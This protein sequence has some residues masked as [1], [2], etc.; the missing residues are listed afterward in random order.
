MAIYTVGV[1][2]TAWVA[3]TCHSLNCRRVRIRENY[4]VLTVQPS[5]D[6]KVRIPSINSSMVAN[7][8]VGGEFELLPVNWGAFSYGDTICEVKTDAG[9]ITL[10]QIEED[11]P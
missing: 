1:D 8:G 3:L 5:Q 6:F 7:V 9:S 2:S 10:L 11:S 4:N